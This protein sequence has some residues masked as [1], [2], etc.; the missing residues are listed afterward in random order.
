M[1]E[2]S[3]LE[4][5]DIFDIK[6]MD[7]QKKISGEPSAELIQS[8]KEKGL[9]RPLQVAEGMILYGKSIY[10]LDGVKRYIACKKVGIRQLPVI[11]VKMT[12]VEYYQHIIH[13]TLSEM[14]NKKISPSL[15]SKL[16]LLYYSTVTNQ[17]K[18]N[19]ILSDSWNRHKVGIKMCAQEF[20]VSE[21]QISRYIRIP[22]CIDEVLELL[23]RKEISLRAAVE[24]SYIN[25]AEQNEILDAF[26]MNNNK[27]TYLRVEYIRILRENDFIMYNRKVEEICKWSEEVLKKRIKELRIEAKTNENRRKV[28]GN[29]ELMNLLC[30]RNMNELLVMLAPDF[31]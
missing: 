10:V 1:S 22:N 20:G 26:K 9:I 29:A 19:D 18:R 30:Q 12:D 6:V 31:N 25:Q 21:R 11:V 28:N 14:K 7:I 24:L 27:M 4:K 8:V 15:L 16:V 23:D 3:L 2:D 17:G 13:K 5:M